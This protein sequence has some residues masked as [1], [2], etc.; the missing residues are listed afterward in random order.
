MNCN[1]FSRLSRIVLILSLF[2]LARY[3]DATVYNVDDSDINSVISNSAQA[4][5]TLIMDDGTYTDLAIILGVSGTSQAPITLLPESVNG[6]TFKGASSRIQFSSDWWIVDGFKWDSVLTTSSTSVI[7]FTGADNNV[8][9]NCTVSN[10]G[11]TTVGSKT[12]IIRV[13][14]SSHDNIIEYNRFDNLVNVG[15]QIWAWDTDTDNTGNII[16]Y[17]H[18][19]NLT[20]FEI[21]QLGQG[22]S[23]AFASQQTVLE[24]NLF[25]NIEMED[26][27]LISSKSSDNILRYNTFRDCSSMLV[28]RTGAH[29]IVEG[30]W[31]FDS[32]GIRVHDRDHIIINNYIEGPSSETNSDNEGIT[33]YCGNMERPY[34]D[35]THYTARNVLVANNTVINHEAEH[36]NV[37]RNST[38][39][40]YP[41]S[42][43]II[44]NLVSNN[45]GIGIEYEAGTN[46][47]WQNNIAY[48][49]GS[50]T[51]GDAPNLITRDPSL[52]F[53]DPIYRP[54]S[55]YAAVDS[56]VTVTDVSDDIEGQDRDNYPDIGADE[57]SQDSVLRSPLTISDVGPYAGQTVQYT[58]TVTPSGSGIVTLDP[59]GGTYELSTVVTMTAIADSSWRFTSWSEDA[60][61]TG[62]V[63]PVSMYDDYNITANFAQVSSTPVNLTVASVEAS[64]DDGNIAA[65]TLD[66]DFDTRWSAEDGPQYLAFD[67]GYIYKVSSLEIAWFNGDQRSSYFQIDISSDSSNWTT[68]LTD[69]SCGTTTA[70]EAFDI[71]DVAARYVRYVGNGNSSNDWNSVTEVNIIGM[72]NSTAGQYTL[73]TG[74][75]GSGSVT[76]DP[77]GGTYNPDTEVELTAV[78]AS[79]WRFDLWS[80]SLSGSQNPDT[81]TIDSNKSVTATFVQVCTLSVNTTGSGSVTL[82]PSGGVYDV[83]TEVI[84]TPVPVSGWEFDSWSG[85]LSGSTVP[86]TITMNANKSITAVFTEQTGEPDTTTVY[87]AADAFVRAGDYADDNFGSETR[88]QLKELALN[89]LYH[90]YIKMDCASEGLND[91]NSATLKL[92]IYYVQAAYTLSIY[93]TSDDWT[94]GGITFNNAPSAGDLVTTVSVSAAGTYNIDVTDYVDAELADDDTIS[95]LLIGQNTNSYIR[96]RETAYDPELEIIT[97]SAEKKLPP[98]FL[99]P[100]IPLAYSL[101]QNWPN[102]FNPVTTIRYELSEPSYVNL[103]VYDINGRL[104]SILVDQHQET[105]IYQQKWSSVSREGR[106]MSTGIYFYKLK[107]GTFQDVK[108]ML[109]VK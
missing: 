99:E 63:K 64:E 55:G 11:R 37:G 22:G 108:K 12:G 1:L 89:Y 4:G 59:S 3:A 67:L 109:L 45:V 26:P 15:V 84:L 87:A 29:A 28:L 68:V 95:F 23:S 94:E 60:S 102:P 88:L 25:Q 83:N 91:C 96:S 107:A 36:I 53:D 43:R 86:D 74:T 32:K 38:Y 82:N 44:N 10:S 17:N 2:F 30:N 80:G 19:V 34:T 21:I 69:T 24:Y 54:Q 48:P 51:A 31:F 75:T 6:V 52:T 104:V 16:R 46:I 35:G 58:L 98:G 41:D 8:F 81:L 70:L 105:G 47:T 61:G 56:G 5:D 66:D 20:A 71:T 27:E 42:C 65:N 78:P 90:S 92:N 103:S 33:L 100:V 101:H 62:S 72:I 50:G 49:T 9:R 77:S 39:P 97:G 7:F 106:T 14:N 73:S 40:Y 76:L 79:G 85:D 18:F 57:Y 93:K 13:M